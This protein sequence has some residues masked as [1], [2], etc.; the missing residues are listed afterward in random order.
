M[1]KIPSRLN[2][3][4]TAACRRVLV[5]VGVGDE[6]GAAL[7]F[8]FLNVLA[9]GAAEIVFVLRLYRFVLPVMRSPIFVARGSVGTLGLS[10]L[11]DKR[12]IVV[13]ILRT[14]LSASVAL[15]NA[16]S[17]RLRSVAPVTLDHSRDELAFCFL[18]AESNALYRLT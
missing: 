12:R 9:I 11:F 15:G 16:A 18:R 14:F 10:G 6:V 8:G 3:C 1:F 5:P 13:S 17:A 7:A 2:R 4:D